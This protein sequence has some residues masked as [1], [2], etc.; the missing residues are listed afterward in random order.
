MARIRRTRFVLFLRDDQPFLDLDPLLEGEAKPAPLRQLYALSLLTGSET[1]ISD[2]D[3]EL[4]LSLPATDWVDPEDLAHARELALAGVVV[5]DEEAPDLV[6]LRRRDE[7]LGAS[8]W[9]VYGA[10]YHL[11]T[12]W[13]DVD[14]R[15][16]VDS[17]HPPDELL[18]PTAEMIREFF[19]VRGPPPE[20][21]P[22]VSA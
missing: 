14:L 16:L 1:A 20:A 13:R 22:A 21:F 4:V 8:D 5:S 12:R 18:A 2:E 17:G 9:N 7:A 10:A 3:L 11:L 15:T 19:D 6:A